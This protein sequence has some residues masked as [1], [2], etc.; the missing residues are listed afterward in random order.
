[1]HPYPR[2]G[3]YTQPTANT[4]CAYYAWGIELWDPRDNTMA[5]CCTNVSR[6]WANVKPAYCLNREVI[7]AWCR[8]TCCTAAAHCCR[9]GGFYFLFYDRAV[10]RRRRLLSAVT[11]AVPRHLDGIADQLLCRKQITVIWFSDIWPENR[12]PFSK[13]DAIPQKATEI[14]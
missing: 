1:M 6:R 2:L 7:S 5:Q 11:P 8:S 13:Q 4:K 12:R 10:Y 3:L 9:S 14:I